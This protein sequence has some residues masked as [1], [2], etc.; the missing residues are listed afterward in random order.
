MQNVHVALKY[1]SFKLVLNLKQLFKK[2]YF[3]PKRNAYTKNK[4]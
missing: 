3:A 2:L 4:S 1:L